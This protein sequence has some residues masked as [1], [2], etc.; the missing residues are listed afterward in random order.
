MFPAATFH[1]RRASGEGFPATAAGFAFGCR[2]QDVGNIKASSATNAAAMDQLMEDSSVV[3][4]AT[5]PIPVI[6]AT[7][8]HIYADYHQTKQ[9]LLAK[10]PHLR[11]T[12]PRSPFAAA[13]ANLGPV[14]VSPPHTNTNNKADGMCLIGALGSFNPDL[15]GHLVL[16]DYDLIIRFPPGCSVLIPSAIVTHSNTPIQPGE[17]RFSLIQYSAGTLFRWVANGY[18]SDLEWY[19]SAT[20]DDVTRR[21]EAP[22][23]RCATALRMFSRWKDIKVKNFTG[24]ARV[25]VWDEGTPVT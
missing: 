8:Y 17:D 23:T 12:F 1:H 4:M 24:R 7:C 9:A 13:T 11:H 6:Q 14:S 3:R 18:K 2:R 15:G 25:E 22:Q 10:N 21:E 19:A 16:W 20:D 5:F